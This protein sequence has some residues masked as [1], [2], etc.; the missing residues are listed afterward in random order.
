MS[1]CTIPKRRLTI[2]REIGKGYFG[3]VY[4][5]QLITPTGN[6]KSVAVKSFKGNLQFESASVFQVNVSAD[7]ESVTM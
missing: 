3:L 2:E 7:N 5:G 6:M 4:K 1:R